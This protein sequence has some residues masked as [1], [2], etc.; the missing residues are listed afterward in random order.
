MSGRFRRFGEG[1]G[2]VGKG[3][4]YL[5]PRPALYPWIIAPI[6]LTLGMLAGAWYASWAWTPWLVNLLLP[7]PPGPGFAQNL[8]NGFA[9]LM[10]LWVFAT[11]ALVL[12]GLFG[13]L[14]APFYDR[15]A[16]AVEIEE[17]GT[18]VED[19]RSELRYV[20]RSIGHSLLAGFLWI[21]AMVALAGLNLI[22]V[23]GTVL[24]LVGSVVVTSFFLAREMTDGAMSR[25]EYDFAHKL[26]IIAAERWTMLGFGMATGALLLVPFLNLL[27]IPVSVVGGTLLFLDLERTDR[28]SS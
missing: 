4:R 1:A 20:W 28:V 26:R 7:R 19:W 16:R 12:Y 18:S 10:V 5:A 14:G 24:E 15:L 22:P 17:G 21:A 2:Y 23:L 27:L 25:R 6:L 3:L 9:L 8:W 13:A 11:T